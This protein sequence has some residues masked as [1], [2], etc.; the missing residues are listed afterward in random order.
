MNFM[1]RSYRVV[2]AMTAALLLMVLFGGLLGPAAAAKDARSARFAVALGAPG[3]LG[4]R[5][6]ITD[7]MA[8]TD[9]IMMTDTMAMTDTIMMT[10][11]M[12]MTDTTTPDDVETVTETVTETMDNADMAP[13]M[14]MLGGT[15]PDDALSPT[16]E[17]TTLD[18]HAR[19]WYVFKYD[20]TVGENPSQVIAELQMDEPGSI[21]FE[22]W[23]QDDLNRWRNGEDFTPTGAGT[24][25]FAIGAGADNRDRTLLRWA[26]G[27]RATVTYYLI[28]ENNTD[29]PM[30]YTLTVNGPTVSFPA[31]STDMSGTTT[32]TD[33]TMADTAI[34]TETAAMDTSAMPVGGTGPDDALTPT[35]Q[36][37]TL[38][39]GERRWYTF[40]VDFDEAENDDD[41]VD[42]D[43]SEALA[44]LRMAAPGSVSFEVWSQDDVD[45]WR[46]GE[47]F[48]PTGAGTPAFAIGEGDDDRDRSLLRWVGSAEATV[49]YYLLVRNNTDMPATYRLLV[50]GPT[51]SF[52]AATMAAPSMAPATP[53]T[54]TTPMTDT[55]TTDDSMAMTDTTALDDTSSMTDTAT[56]SMTGMG[57]DAADVIT[58]QR[59]TLAAGEQRWYTFEYVFDEES[60]ADGIPSNAIVELRMAQP[61][62]L[63][64]EVWTGENVRQWQNSEDFT[65]TGMGT[66]AFAIAESGD[67]RDRSL[68]RWVGSSEGSVRYYIIVT[69]NSDAPVAYRLTVTG[70]DVRD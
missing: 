47:D 2:A 29:N 37:T 27:S 9:T 69:N 56:M 22:V 18:P 28:V 8:M 62:A 12:A 3:T 51:V 26:G 36:R 70:P 6:Q 57:P 13:A 48:T 25:A 63:S 49:T 61:G 24:P 53:L 23:S 34:M 50:S 46:N 41:L 44:E 32:M 55:P 42:N 60:D 52:P 67:T 15:G 33:T 66:P 7:T 4:Q 1:Q 20:Y 31:M 5:Q 11:T 17:T 30:N 40:K 21:S 38:A 19:R 43:A 68:L 65:P 39:A 45:R 16:G 10:D 35:G 59:A 54:A 58:G 14:S 64:F